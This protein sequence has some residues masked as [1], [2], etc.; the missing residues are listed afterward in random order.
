M[1]YFFVWTVGGGARFPIAVVDSECKVVVV[2][3]VDDIPSSGGSLVAWLAL[4][5]RSPLPGT[6][7]K[8]QLTGQLDEGWYTNITGSRFNHSY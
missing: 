8:V 5:G 1:A 2:H 7:K 4:Y 3:V 6:Q